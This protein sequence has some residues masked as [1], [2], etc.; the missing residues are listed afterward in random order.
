MCEKEMIGEERLSIPMIIF[1]GLAPGLIIFFWVHFFSNPIFGINFFM[2]LSVMLAVIL[3]LI[4]TQLG[5]LKFIAWRKNKKIA[6]LILYK[7]KTSKMRLV[8]SIIIPLIFAG[9]IFSIIPSYEIRLLKLIG[10]LPDEFK[11]EVIAL[12]DVNKIILV[13]I[14]IFNGI[15]GPIVEE[16]Y[17]RGFLLPRMGIFGKF[18][19]LIN[20]IIFSIYHFFSPWQNIT[21]II[22]FTPTAYSVWINKDIKIG[23]I[24]HC[25]LNVLGNISM[26][27]LINKL[28]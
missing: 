8:I 18:A 5:I 26:I 13:L 22:G 6:D 7:N 24:V 2:D 25:L 4:P 10:L 9:I 16:I 19:P 1:L 14:F 23:M 17:F 21:R 20:I 15:F 3:G 11:P 27:I 12:R 28:I